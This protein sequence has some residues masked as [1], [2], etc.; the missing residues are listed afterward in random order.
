[1]SDF[2]TKVLLATDGSKDAALAARV[3]VDLSNKS[4]A[5]LH[6]VHAWMPL[7]HYAYP[8]LVEEGYFPPYEQ[9]ARKVL[10]EQVHRIREIGGK[11]EG[12]YLK[13]GRPSDVILKLGDDIEA[14]LI[15]LGSRGLGPVRRL[16]LG[17]VSEEVVHHARRPVLVARGG[18]RAWPPEQ[19]V[20]G[21]DG[22][23][24][25]E[26]TGELAA[27]IA[28]LYG[29]RATLV[30]AEPKPP[31]PP[32]LPEYEHGLYERLV[33]DYF[34]GERKR[35]EERAGRIAELTG[36][37]PEVSFVTEDPTSAILTAA[38]GS[39]STMVAVGF[40]GRGAVERTILGSVS[41]K[42]L[43]VAEGPVLVCPR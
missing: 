18:E 41:T 10:V 12:D 28:D 5:E 1:M 42:V 36:L 13:S 25:A 14:D 38:K 43:R 31:R 24:E 26:R 27:G 19:V 37:R 32:D 23:E 7:P 40:R 11:I 35:L 16:V 6:I 17:S 22:S 20:V 34:R 29:A 39:V 33:K 15:V 4:D 8:S 30:G 3:A 21:D 9:G 2:L